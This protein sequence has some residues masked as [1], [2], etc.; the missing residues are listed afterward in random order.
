M[1]IEN[2]RDIDPSALL[3]YATKHWDNREGKLELHTQMKTS[4]D[5]LRS[6]TIHKREKKKL[7][8]KGGQIAKFDKTIYIFGSWYQN[9]VIPYQP[10]VSL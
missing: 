5:S 9:F 3:L 4:I 6:K 1:L 10:L 7:I 2:G 8:S